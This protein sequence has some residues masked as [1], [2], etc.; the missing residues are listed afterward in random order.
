VPPQDKRPYKLYL[1]ANKWAI[2]SDVVQEFEGK[3]RIIYF[4][5]RRLLDAETRYS[6]V[7][8]SCLC[9]CFSCT[10]LKAYLLTVECIVIC[11]DDMVKH[12]LSLPILRVESESGVWLYQN[13]I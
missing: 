2:R 6:T 8:R 10:K 7:E 11:K 9:L 13:L 5:S 4:L 3:E 12:M 1:S